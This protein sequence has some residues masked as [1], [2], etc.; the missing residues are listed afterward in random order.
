MKGWGEGW[1][2]FG[3]WFKV[4]VPPRNYNPTTKEMHKGGGGRW[5]LCIQSI[6]SWRRIERLINL[7]FKVCKSTAAQSKKGSRF[8]KPLRSL[9]YPFPG[10]G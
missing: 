7:T 2:F 10:K 5:R 8:L 4:V 1:M 6:I 3:L 9:N